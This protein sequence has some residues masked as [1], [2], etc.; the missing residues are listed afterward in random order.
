[1]T[2]S[3]TLVA[4]FLQRGLDLGEEA[5]L[6]AFA[7]A[8]TWG[9][10]KRTEGVANLL[11]WDAETFRQIAQTGSIRA[12]SSDWRDNRRPFPV[13]LTLPALFATDAPAE[14]ATVWDLLARDEVGA[15]TLSVL[16]GEGPRGAAQSWRW[17]LRIGIAPGAEPG[18]LEALDRTGMVRRGLARIALAEDRDPSCD[19]LLVGWDEDYGDLSAL[20]G[21]LPAPP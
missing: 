13:D 18:I 15:R 3:E 4:D 20:T 12:L 16:D 9:H 2:D 1:M 5:R 6:T 19:I 14:A 21:L 8:G 7:S 10:R 17:P 11:E